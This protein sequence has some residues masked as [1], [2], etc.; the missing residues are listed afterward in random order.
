MM[1][2]NV[3]APLNSSFITPNSSFPYASLAVRRGELY[4][5]PALVR[6]APS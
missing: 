1:N 4:N 2:E 6:H 3:P 5:R